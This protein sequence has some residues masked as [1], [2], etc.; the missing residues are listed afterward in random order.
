MSVR[1]KIVDKLLFR[2]G[3]KDAKLTVFEWLGIGILC[4]IALIYLYPLVWMC[5][6]SF[7]PMTE[8]FNVPPALFQKPIW[9]SVKTYSLSSYIS[10]FTTHNVGM[11][12]FMSL[13]VTCTG[14]MF[15][16]MV[17]SLCAYGFVYL[18]FP[19]RKVLFLVI[20]GTMMLPM[21]TM[22]APA[23][24]VISKLGLVDNPLGIILP[25]GMS[26]FGVFLLRQFYIRIPLS[27]V[28]SAR[29]DGAGHLKIWW[30]IILPLSR[31]ALAALAIVQFRV[32]WNDFL[33]PMIVLK[34]ESFFTLPIRIMLIDSINYNK[35]YDVIITAGF[36]TAAV[37]MLVFLIFQRHFIEGLTGGVKE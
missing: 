2:F 4:L 19:G 20:L 28:E 9:E 27:I 15:T 1:K 30:N 25:Y 21:A 31:P 32:I 37:P 33:M 26:A 35:P 12:F 14:I 22:I 7:R 34:S 11:A 23:Y 29:V 6:S 13:L 36:I 3:F 17:C 10:A 5:D 18:E 8:I 16:L 24:R